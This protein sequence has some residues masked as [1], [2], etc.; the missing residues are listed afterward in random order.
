MKTYYDILE[1]SRH[2]SLEVIKRA[3]NVLVK[4]YHPDL[5]NPEDVKAMEEK[6]IE[7]NEAYE[8]LIDPVKKAKYDKFLEQQELLNQNKNAQSSNEQSKYNKQNAEKLE[9]ELA[10]KKLEEEV[11]KRVNE[12]Q[13]NIDLQRE[14]IQEQ[15]NEDYI[16]YLRNMGYNVKTTTK[17]PV[18]EKIKK[19]LIN[20]SIF[21]IFFIIFTVI[22]RVPAIREKINALEE[23]NLGF[24]MISRIIAFIIDS[25]WGIFGV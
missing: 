3:H 14:K 24:K 4:K 6:M 8:T 20:V 2:A 21:L 18:K 25:I 17:T 23:K 16:R 9:I 10:N 11:E 7:I 19:I 13:K 15:M 1:V 12:A 5:Q 22:Y